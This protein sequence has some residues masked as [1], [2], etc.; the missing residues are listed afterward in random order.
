MAY[1]VGDYLI[2]IRGTMADAEEFANTWAVKD[3]GDDVGSQDILDVFHVFYE[4]LATG[5]TPVWNDAT[6]IT[7][8]RVVNLFDGLDQAV[9]WDSIQGNSDVFLLPTECALR[10]SIAVG[11][12]RRGGPFLPP[13]RRESL[14]KDGR[15]G[16]GYQAAVVSAL[17]DLVDSAE[18]AGW[19]L[20]L[21][22]PTDLAV[23]NAGA[24]K[25][26]RV[27][28]VIRKRR[29]ELPEAYSS[30]VMP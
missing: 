10:V 15:V 4:T 18:I 1:A 9:T 8:A 27:F 17:Q 20:G 25:V 11:G 22:S 19:K 16:T 30:V 5:A 24:V 6:F 28:D 14:T 23:Y 2:T 3:V 12:H 26:G 7:Q 13:F 29:N 21:H